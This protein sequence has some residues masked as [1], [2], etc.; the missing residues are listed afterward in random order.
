MGPRRGS[1]ST[2]GGGSISSRS[3]RV[4][5]ERRLRRMQEGEDTP[6][7]VGLQTT[8]PSSQLQGIGR[9]L[10]G[11]ADGESD[12]SAEWNGSGVDC[13]QGEVGGVEDHRAWRRAG[14]ECTRAMAL[15]ELRRVQGRTPRSLSLRCNGRERRLRRMQEGEDTPPRVGLQTI[16]P[17]S[18]RPG[19]RKSQQEHCNRL[20]AALQ[21]TINTTVKF[22]GK[23]SIFTRC[24]YPPCTPV[25]NASIISI[26]SK[27]PESQLNGGARAAVRLGQVDKVCGF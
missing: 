18:K 25:R 10:N 16:T 14:K 4:R 1:C 24:V 9:Y 12:D 21:Q 2:R 8:C 6:P 26:S 22:D 13:G 11:Y 3:A 17:Q 27:V 7:R 23:A 19:S 15:R 20:V 5:A